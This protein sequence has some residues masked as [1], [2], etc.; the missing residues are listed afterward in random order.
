MTEALQI[1][2]D[3]ALDESIRR[4]M[5][6]LVG[7]VRD[8][9]YSRAGR[10]SVMPHVSHGFGACGSEEPATVG[11]SVVVRGCAAA[12]PPDDSAGLKI[13][14]NPSTREFYTPFFCGWNGQPSLSTRFCLDPGITLNEL[15]QS[16]FS[17]LSTLR[18]LPNPDYVFLELMG[19]FRPNEISDRALKR[20][21]NQGN[22]LTTAAEH[23][24]R[25]FQTRI[26]FNDLASHRAMPDELVPLCIVG[27]GHCGDNSNLKD[28]SISARIFYLPPYTPTTAYDPGQIRT[29]NH[30]LGWRSESQYVQRLLAFT[31]MEGR[32]GS[33]SIAGEQELA[34]QL[35][36]HQPDYLV[37]LDDWSTVRAGIVKIYIAH[38]ESF[39]VHPV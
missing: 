32:P 34:D 10:V 30:G 19:L 5:P 7:D 11:E 39:N 18:L 17:H 3:G 37:H 23:A 31:Q 24:D 29:H 2:L 8:V 35:L 27:A 9:I 16:I 13:N 1:Q 38:N 25:F 6:I 36:K 21:V 26:I 22:V 12:T 20:P 33:G 4:T 28:D 15:Y 14:Y